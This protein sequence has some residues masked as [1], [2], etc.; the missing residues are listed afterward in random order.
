[1]AYNG[2]FL[3]CTVTI[4]V[5]VVCIGYFISTTLELEVSHCTYYDDWICRC[6]R[7]VMFGSWH[8]DRDQA[9]GAES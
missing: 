3:Q 1:M 2:L 5:C 9:R 4:L 8:R 6:R 7:E